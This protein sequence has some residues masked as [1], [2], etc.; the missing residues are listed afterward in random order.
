MAQKPKTPPVVQL[1]RYWF[2][3]TALTMI[4]SVYKQT[5]SWYVSKK[6]RVWLAFKGHDVTLYS[7]SAECV[8]P[9][10]DRG[11]LDTLAVVLAQ[12]LPKVLQVAPPITSWHGGSH[13]P[14]EVAEEWE[15]CQQ[16]WAQLI[17][18]LPEEYAPLPHIVYPQEDPAG[19]LYSPD[20]PDA[21]N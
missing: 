2:V 20:D 19:P 1:D 18:Q 7:T 9:Y 6:G 21:Q 5:F 13:T 14:E 15:T 16:L 12:H 3:I 11:S 4:C 17:E 8:S 10:T